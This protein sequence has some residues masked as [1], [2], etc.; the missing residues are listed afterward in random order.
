MHLSFEPAAISAVFSFSL[1]QGEFE[2]FVLA[3]L[4]F[5]KGEGK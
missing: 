2:V 3:S 4:V 5:R 1:S